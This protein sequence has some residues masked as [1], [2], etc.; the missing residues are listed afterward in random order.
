MSEKPSALDAVKI[1][2][3]VVIP[4]V[5]ALE[6]ELGT[7][8][9]HSIVGRAIAESYAEWQGK[10]VSALRTSIRGTP[11]SRSSSPSKPTSRLGVSPLPSD[12]GGASHCD[13]RWRLRDSGDDAGVTS[14]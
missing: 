12:H 3:R 9:A 8:R 11:T 5:S 14:H 13:F 10:A 2:A 4:I 6:H 1:Q 7:G